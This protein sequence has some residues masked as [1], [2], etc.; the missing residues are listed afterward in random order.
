MIFFL[1]LL[2]GTILSV[3]SDSWFG[4]WCGL[5][6]NLMS[7]I[8][9]ISS[10]MNQYS[11]EAC[12]KYFLIQA[13]GSSIIVLGFIFIMISSSFIALM[14]F[15]LLLKLGAAPV[16]F[17]FPQVM[18]GLNWNQC[19]IL[20]TLQ[21][22]APMYLVSY[23][24]YISNNLIVFW[25]SII[26]AMV[27]ALGGVNQ[28]FLRKL[29]A[30]SSINHMSWM[31]M[32]MLV[33]EN[34]WSLYFIFYSFISASIV[35]LFNYQQFFHLNQLS[36]FTNYKLGLISFMSLLSLG[37]LPPFSG[38]IPKWIIIQELVFKS[39]FFSLLIF[40]LSSLV[41]LYYYLR[42]TIVYM[43]FLSPKLKFNLMNNVKSK[44]VSFFMSLNF[45]G[46]I[47]PSMFMLM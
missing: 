42:V 30:F 47:F 13:L 46:L 10:S 40:L 9:F 32:S 14:T 1:T 27:G 35:V 2:S 36:N 37:G 20:M 15:A 44:K 34:S 7:F 6:L 28:M 43:T 22:I 29:L 19:L 26:S 21:K 18:E 17:W 4:A 5:E 16:H 39:Y 38:F 31:L 8:P 25:S 3:S 11:S 23:T 45:I 41:T 24:I 33:S 12:L